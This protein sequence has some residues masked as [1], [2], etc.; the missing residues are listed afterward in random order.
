[1]V[2]RAPPA[3]PPE[4]KLY[5]VGVGLN[6][7]KDQEIPQLTAS[8]SDARAFMDLVRKR[9][10][11]LY[12]VD[13]PTMLTDAAVTPVK[14]Q[15]T[16]REISQRLKDTVRPDDLLVIFV[17][18]HGVED[19]ATK[20]YYFVGHEARLADVNGRKYDD[21]I[22]CKDFHL[23]ADL[24]C[25]KLLLLDTCH[26]GAL[27]SRNK[28]A[29]RDFQEDVIFTVTA[30]KADERAA[31][32]IALGQGLFTR[33]LL[34]ALAGRADSSNDGYVSLLEMV[35]YLKTRVPE[36]VRKEYPGVEQNPTAA[37][38]ELL[39]YVDGLRLTSRE[40]TSDQAPKPVTMVERF[41]VLD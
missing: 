17:A 31:E 34:E 29:V 41:G 25:R 30:T 32:D 3:A 6:Q 2:R 5:L 4:P 10:T 40:T 12:T 19:A 37:P 33:C 15:Q 28:A 22:S 27:H 36:I 21:C 13:D 7:Y 38:D 39:P 14:W 8:I 35:D 23:L 11:Q 1:V 20:Q 24:P 16:M 18:G 26:A 9:A